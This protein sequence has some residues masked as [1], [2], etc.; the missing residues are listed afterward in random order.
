[1]KIWI[2]T[3]RYY[4]GSGSGVL[5]T[6]YQDEATAHHVFSVLVQQDNVKMYELEELNVLRTEKPNWPDTYRRAQT[7]RPPWF[8]LIGVPGTSLS[9]L[10]L[11]VRTEA[12]LKAEGVDTVEKL[13]LCQESV[14][15]RFPN[16]GRKSLNEINQTLASKGMRLQP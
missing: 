3:W 13:M 11:S 16:L 8:D 2:I 12:C 1:M 4:D 7:V 9:E 14:L 6:A 5:N 15:L 10:N